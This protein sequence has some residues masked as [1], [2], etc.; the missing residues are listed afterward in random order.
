MQPKELIKNAEKD[1]REVFERIDDIRDFNQEKV[2]RA[3]VDNKVAP[4]HF[5][6]VSGYGHDDIGREVLD[7]VFAQVFKAEKALARIHFVS[8]THTLACALFGNLRHGDKLVSVAGAPYDTMQE[9]IGCIEPK[10]ESL[11][12]HGVLYEEIPLLNDMD[13]DFDALERTIDETVT[14]VLI[15]R[16]RGYSLRKSLS[17]ETIEKICKIVKSKNPNTICFVDNCYG[18]FVDTKEPL[19]VG[20]DLMAGS[21]IKNPGGGIV[22]AGGYIAGKEQYVEQAAMRLTAPGIAGE[23]GAMFNQH[24]LIFQGLFMAPSVVSDAV[25]GAVLAAKI[26]EEI[27]YI[28]TPKFD[29]KRTDIIQTIAFG[30]P[31]PLENFC[32]TIQELSP[33]NAYVTPI[34]DDVPGYEDKII[35]AG[36][37]FIEG[38]TIELSADGPLRPPYAVY[39][40]GGLNY[41][42]VKIVLENILRKT[43]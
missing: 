35:M 41:A 8:G 6:T 7:N 3:F 19:E 42:H 20:A 13:V 16:S 36:G 2:L 24:R 37:T 25:K 22:E 26:F 12:G 5:Y 9:V 30:E 32:K 11:I 14:M 34:P 43:M 27:G 39:M 18:E 4:E 28:S 38:S 1:L 21:L 17:I 23:G 33:V 29:E 40:Q 31:E 10:R 15:Q